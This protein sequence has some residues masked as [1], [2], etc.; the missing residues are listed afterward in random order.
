MGYY[1]YHMKRFV[2]ENVKLML[3]LMIGLVI[4]LVPPEA[5]FPGQDFIPQFWEQKALL[6]V[7][8]EHQEVWGLL[9][10]I[11][12]CIWSVKYLYKELV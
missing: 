11:T 9:G 8:V 10:L 2:K 4:L 6:F 1:D 5:W 12:I 3:G 7:L